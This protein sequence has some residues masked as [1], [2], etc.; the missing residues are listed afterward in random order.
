MSLE[1]ALGI[2]VHGQGTTKDD[3]ALVLDG[4]V[5]N[6]QTRA[7]SESLKARNGSGHPAGG[8]VEYKRFA[9]AVLEDY[10]TARSGYKGAN[11]VAKPIK[12]LIDTD[13][14]IIEEFAIKDVELYGIK[15]LVE[16]RK[17]NIER[18]LSAFLDREFFARAVA[19][20]TAFDRNGE[21][22]IV[23]IVDAMIVKAKST[24]SDFIDGID[25]EDLAFVVSPEWRKALK[26]HLN[27]LP[28]GTPAENGLI[29]TYDSVDFHESHRLGTGVN[30]IIMLKEAVAQPYLLSEYGVEKIPFVNAVALESYI[31]K[32]DGVLAS[33]AVLYDREAGS[34]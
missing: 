13:K 27:E 3:L 30:G 8:T 29:G 4:V 26:N 32:G 14:E 23:K 11:V 1:K 2:N 21:T 24:T 18:R 22:D 9:N 33:E 34:F 28:Q 10:G 7:V 25:A 15:A 31:S 12:I 5:E 6:I 19:D 17:T 20:G 16:R